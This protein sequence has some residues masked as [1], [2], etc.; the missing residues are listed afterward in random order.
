MSDSESTILQ[1]V[2]ARVAAWNQGRPPAERLLVPEPPVIQATQDADDSQPWY[3]VI[4]RRA[5]EAAHF[6][7][8]YALSYLEAELAEEDHPQVLLV[9]VLPS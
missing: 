3:W 5:D 1:A 7:Y 6:P 2:R 9:P 4:V 8:H